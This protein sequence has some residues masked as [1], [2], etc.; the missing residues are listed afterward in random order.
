LGEG[1]RAAL[2]FNGVRGLASFPTHEPQH[3]A[4]IKYEAELLEALPRAYDEI[5]IER[6]RLG[7]DRTVAAL[8][9]DEDRVK[10][11]EDG[12]DRLISELEMVRQWLD[13]FVRSAEEYAAARP[14]RRGLIL[15]PSLPSVARKY[16]SIEAF[17]AEDRARGVSDWDTRKVA[18]GADFG[19][20]WTW[21]DP[22]RPWVISEWRV[23][24]IDELKEV[25][26]CESALN[27][28]VPFIAFDREAERP[29]AVWLLATDFEISAGHDRGERLQ[30]GFFSS[31]PTWEFLSQK[32]RDLMRKR[33]SLVLLAE[34]LTEE[35]GRHNGLSSRQDES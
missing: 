10:T 24:Y 8:P 12:R 30:S 35:Q 18:S 1:G 2:P 14:E 31:S 19:Y 7:R 23:S 17:V 16:D 29:R 22:E 13:R 25:Y 15:P 21:Q 26:A 28:W 6:D 20:D 4:V 34:A 9:G 33:N 27:R 3:E 32:Q 11:A 5:R